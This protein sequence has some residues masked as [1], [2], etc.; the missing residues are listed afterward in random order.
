MPLGSFHKVEVGGHSLEIPS[1][2]EPI[3]VIGSGSFGLVLS[4]KDK[5]TDE[6]VAIKKIV[7]VFQ[8]V[9]DM[10]RLLREMKLMRHL[11]HENI[12]DLRDAFGTPP[13]SGRPLEELFLV[14]TLMES[15]LS[16]IVRSK[17]PL[18][19]EHTQYFMYQIMRG[20]KYMHSANVIHR[21]L[22][23]SNLLLNRTCDLR[24]CDLGLAR[25]AGPQG[26]QKNEMLTE[27][28]VTRWYRA[29]E[30]MLSSKRYGCPVDIWGAG[31]IFG[32]LLQR[33]PM[34]PGHDYI[35]QVNQ[36]VK[37]VGSPTDKQTSFIA[38]EKALEYVKSLP[39]FKRA[40]MKSFFPGATPEAVSLL[41]ALLQINPADRMHAKDSLYHSYF[42]SLHDE[43]DE[44]D[45]SQTF[46]FGYE[47]D[48][49]QKTKDIQKELYRVAIFKEIAALH[50]E[51]GPEYKN[52][53][54]VGGLPDSETSDTKAAKDEE[55]WKWGD[56]EGGQGKG[57]PALPISMT[58][59][60]GDND[61]QQQPS[62]V[63]P[64]K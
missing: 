52:S 2:Y 53:Y 37:F 26:P 5:K 19:P 47:K 39:P 42:S 31:C 41:D 59:C 23:P 35:D 15:D 46:D 22:K 50:P 25:D 48:F 49:Q 10:K 27:Y 9:N 38:N 8:Q 29:P 64:K 51:L 20:L 21:D 57:N 11:E 3:K 62:L 1:R 24:I 61:E 44:P 30:V 34:F 14:A 40:D 18:L 7:K 33:K 60:G 36:I 12:I 13:N 58:K 54:P 43:A 56:E 17:Q 16:R 32:E 55:D 63:N 28:V 45:C 6:E 4:A